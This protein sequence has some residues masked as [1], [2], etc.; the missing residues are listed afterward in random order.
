VSPIVGAERQHVQGS[1]GRSQ[2]SCL[3]SRRPPPRAA[4]EGHRRLCFEFVVD[5]RI[6]LDVDDERRADHPTP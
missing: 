6:S 1:Q 4:A 5:R 3:H 2:R